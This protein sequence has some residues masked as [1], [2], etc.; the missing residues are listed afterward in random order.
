MDLAEGS[1]GWSFAEIC[2][3]LVGVVLMLIVFAAHLESVPIRARVTM[4]ENLCAAIDFVMMHSLFPVLSAPDAGRG[5]GMPAPSW[6][7][8]VLSHALGR[9][10]HVKCALARAAQDLGVHGAG[11]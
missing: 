10:V 8:N 4:H 11:K 2:I 3:P 7:T 9:H 5:S 6:P 1:S